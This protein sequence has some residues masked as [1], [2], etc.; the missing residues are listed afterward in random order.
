MSRY[1]SCLS[2]ATV[3]TSAYPGHY[4]RHSLLGK[5]QHILHPVGTCS[6]HSISESKDMVIP[7]LMLVLPSLRVT[8]SAGF[9]G[10][11]YWSEGVL[12]AP[13]SFPFWVKPMNLRRLVRRNDGSDVPSLSL[14]IA[15]CSQRRPVRFKAY[16]VLSP[17]QGLMVSRYPGGYAFHCLLQRLGIAPNIEHQVVK[18]ISP[19]SPS[20]NV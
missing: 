5:S 12:P 6:E 19:S 7:F 14:L 18:V 11:R 16:L 9:S 8:L 1:S 13:T 10:S 15:S 4:P 17:L 2:R 20:L 3:P